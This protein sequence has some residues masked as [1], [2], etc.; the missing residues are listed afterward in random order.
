MQAKHNGMTD[1]AVFLRS[2]FWTLYFFPHSFHMWNLSNTKSQ[3]RRDQQYIWDQQEQQHVIKVL[4]HFHF[5]KAK[6][7]IL[8]VTLTH[9]H[10]AKITTDLIK[11]KLSLKKN[12][13]LKTQ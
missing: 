3:I 6:R 11:Q 4:T 5:S 7:N 1:E 2:S 10:S 9:K 12:L 13:R 8:K